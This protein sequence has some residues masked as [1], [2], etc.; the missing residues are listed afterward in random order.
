MKP[1]LTKTIVVS[2]GVLAGIFLVGLA[3]VWLITGNYSQSEGPTRDRKPPHIR[4]VSPADGE[5]V[6][7]WR[8]YCVH[9]L[10]RVGTGMGKNPKNKINAYLDGEDITASI[11]GVISLDSPP[12]YANYCF[13]TSTTLLPG[14]HTAKV[15]YS[16]NISNNFSYTW[17]ILVNSEQKE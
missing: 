5:E 9:F 2:I 12:S 16:D 15:T 14:W 13:N 1:K 11:T 8:G 3:I 6:T 17:R 7:E 10:F 4:Q